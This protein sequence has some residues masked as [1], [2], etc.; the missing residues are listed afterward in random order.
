MNNEF[1]LIEN[2]KDIKL[3]Y[4]FNVKNNLKINY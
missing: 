1:F 2:N 4:K 3:I